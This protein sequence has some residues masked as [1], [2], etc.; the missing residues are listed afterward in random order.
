MLNLFR[1]LAA[2]GGLAAL[3][4]VTASGAEFP[5]GSLAE[6]L[7]TN[8]AARVAGLTD[9]NRATAELSG[10]DYKADYSGTNLVFLTRCVWST[11]CWLAG[12]RGLGAT[13]IGMVTNNMGGQGLMTMISPRHYLCATHMHPEGRRAAF[14]DTNNVLHWRSTLQRIDLPPA[15]A[16]GI[17]ADISVGILDADL[18]PSV[19]FLPVLPP[20]Y[21]SYLPTGRGS[22]V[23][24]L[25]HIGI[26]AHFAIVHSLFKFRVPDFPPVKCPQ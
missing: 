21:P 5:P 22:L 19:G 8:A 13:P 12:V 1:R 17:G 10:W 23:Q 20:D 2:L 15:P 7:S 26:G 18:P 9:I 6:H 14:L 25:R 3:T 24:G 4:A 16:Q 11:N